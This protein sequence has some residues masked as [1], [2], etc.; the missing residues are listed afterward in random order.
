MSDNFVCCI[1]FKTQINMQ[2]QFTSINLRKANNRKQ[3]QINYIRK[4]T[5]R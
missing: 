5:M 3:V 4:L 2:L 1:V